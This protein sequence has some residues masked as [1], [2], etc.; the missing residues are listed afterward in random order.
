MHDAAGNRITTVT[1]GAT[2]NYN[3]NNLNQYTSVGGYAYSYDADGN[4][5]SKQ[6]SAGTWAYTYDDEGHLLTA[7]GPSGSWTYQYNSLG[8][9]SRLST[10]AQ[11][12]ST[13]SILRALAV[14]MGSSMARERS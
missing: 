5:I 8:E 6:T 2:T 7:S 14:W 9:R 12:H 4:L 10:A 11:R 13:W 1:G 3:V